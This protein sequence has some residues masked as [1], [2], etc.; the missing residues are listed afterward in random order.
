VALAFLMVPAPKAILK[1][2][3]QSHLYST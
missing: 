3:L 2:N 1:F